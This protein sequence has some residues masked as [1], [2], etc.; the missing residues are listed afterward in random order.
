MTIT[1]TELHGSGQ[2]RITPEGMRGVRLFRVLDY[3]LATQ[4]AAGL[5][6]DAQWVAGTVERRPPKRFA[7]DSPM[8]CREVRIEGLGKPSLAIDGGPHYDGGARLIATYETLPFDPEDDDPAGESPGRFLTESLSIGG[9]LVT[10]PK[11]AFKWSSDS[12]ELAEADSSPGRLLPQAEYRLTR[13][14]V[15][16]LPKS[17]IFAALGKV[18]GSTFGQAA[19]G[20]L[21]FLGAEARREHTGGGSKAW[22]IDL[23]FAY[24]PQGHNNQFRASTGEFEQLVTKSGGDALYDSADFAALVPETA[25]G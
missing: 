22:E 13:H 2:V 11:Q 24:E 10:L 20:T 19:A 3:A 9:R 4:I 17:V 25:G 18:N 8:Y 14:R 23:R 1:A 12:G 6:G 15:P 5:L 16:T 7:P 21:L